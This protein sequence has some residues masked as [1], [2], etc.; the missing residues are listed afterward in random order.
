[1]KKDCKVLIRI[2]FEDHIF[3]KNEIY[4]YDDKIA[5]DFNDHPFYKVYY[6]SDQHVLVPYGRFEKWFDDLVVLRK[7][8]LKK[9]ADKLKNP[10]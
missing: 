2:E 1:V 8:K 10:L 7:M 4:V 5:Y 6:N 9:I 3:E